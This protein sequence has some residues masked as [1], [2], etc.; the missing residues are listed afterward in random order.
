MLGHCLSFIGVSYFG[1]IMMLL[2]LMFAIVGF[3][4]EMSMRQSEVA[5]ISLVATEKKNGYI[6]SYN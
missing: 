3:V 2:Y 4:Y 5:A 6:H 1:Q